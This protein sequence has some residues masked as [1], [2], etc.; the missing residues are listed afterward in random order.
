[1]IA[2]SAR[3]PRRLVSLLLS[4]AT[5]LTLGAVAAPSVRAAPPARPL[6]TFKVSFED[7]ASHRFQV[8]AHYTGLKGEQTILFL[9][10]WTPGSYL[11]RDHA[12]HVQRL[13][14]TDD[15]GA[16]LA[17]DRPTTN[18]WR[19]H[20]PK[21]NKAITVRYEVY[22]HELTVRTNFVDADFALLAGA[23]TWILPVAGD[24]PVEVTV[25][26]P[27]GWPAIATPLAV[28]A[29]VGTRDRT[30][31][32]TNRDRLIDSPVLVGPLVQTHFEVAGVAHTLVDLPPDQSWRPSQAA[33][34]FQRVA[35]AAQAV[36]G[37]FPDDLKHYQLINVLAGGGGGLEHADCAVL[38]D[39]AHAMAK[40]EGYRGWLRLAAHEYFHLWN[41]KRLRPVALGPFDYEQPVLTDS[42]WI[43]EGITAYYDGLL[44]KRAGLS[45]E[46]DWLEALQDKVER[47]DK[48]PGAKVRSLALASRD[49]WI[50][51]Y[52]P[53]ENSI[54]SDV[55]YYLKGALVAW[56]LDAE[57]RLATD[58]ARSLDDVM[59][60]AMKRYAGA[61]GYT[62]AQF[63]AVASEVAGR[64]LSGF[65]NAAVRGTG[66]LDYAS[67]LRAFG[68]RFKPKKAEGA[69][70]KAEPA[71]PVAKPVA[72]PLAEPVGERAGA[73]DAPAGE[74]ET[75]AA[76]APAADVDATDEDETAADPTETSADPTETPA[77]SKSTAAAAKAALA[78]G[79]RAGEGAWLGIEADQRGTRCF[80]EAVVDASPA[81]RAGLSA[82]D[83]LLG[84]DDERVPDDGPEALLKRLPPGRKVALWISRRGRLRQLTAELAAPP[85][86]RGELVVDESAGPEVIR[87]RRRWLSGPP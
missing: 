87:A 24:G 72:E 14:A 70:S 9:P 56:L 36:F 19:V 3:P 35:R 26:L 82:G 66:P 46:A 67:A 49:A 11:V 28:V 84:I 61:R 74:P 44:V 38:M 58:H 64:D 52:R 29:G 53:D 23:A 4:L 83:E 54:N 27:D 62:D 76:E 21:K 32:A 45:T 55:S 57:I 43:A 65:F 42:L 59:R 81:Q 2:L 7:R 18:R 10:V 41:V 20:H 15:S 5:L 30:Y 73:A 13:V 31:R 33:L 8:E 22:A 16:E 68:L 40:T 34:D 50:R 69:S 1:M 78:H 80:V 47:L 51:A 39:D 12:R 17:V 6:A 77:D 48:T 25:G 79:S 86:P 71:S 75:G 63:E 60:L 37:A 85:A